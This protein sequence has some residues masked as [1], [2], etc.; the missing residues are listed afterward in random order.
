MCC[1]PQLYETAIGHLCIPAVD[2]DHEQVHVPVLSVCCMRLLGLW[3]HL[4]FLEV[5]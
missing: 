2:S 1:T 4:A 5:L 3:S